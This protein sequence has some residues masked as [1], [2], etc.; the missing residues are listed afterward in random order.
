M[1][2]NMAAGEWSILHCCI[3]AWEHCIL[4]LDDAAHQF[5]L[6]LAYP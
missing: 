5:G 3:A 1:S 4:L 6:G 2:G